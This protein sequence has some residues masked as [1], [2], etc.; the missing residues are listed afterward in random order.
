MEME[1]PQRSFSVIEGDAVLDHRGTQ[2]GLGG[3]AIAP[4]PGEVPPRIGDSLD[5]DPDH[6]WQ[7]RLM[8]PHRLTPGTG[9]RSPGRSRAAM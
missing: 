6:A 8:K 7:L 5:L 4:R 9:H 2:A 3:L 1:A